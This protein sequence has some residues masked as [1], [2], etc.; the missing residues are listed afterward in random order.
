MKKVLAVVAMVCVVLFAGSA[1]AQPASSSAEQAIGQLEAKMLQAANAHDT[2]A[3]M[4]SMLHS[5]SL[6]L[7]FNGK[8]IRGWNALH[9]Q[10]LKWWRNGKSDA[11][12]AHRSPPEFMAL[13]PGVE[14]V[15]LLNVSSRTGPDGKVST[16]TFVVT[17]VWQH[18]PQGWRIVYSHESW[19]KPPH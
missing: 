4:A 8:V 18:L 1:F 10:Q 2:D 16:G 17:D 11:T 9:A 7:V 3:F 6:V 12:Y 19:A 5:S 15:T 14:L 13:A